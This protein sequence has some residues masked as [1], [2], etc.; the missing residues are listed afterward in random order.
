MRLSALHLDRPVELV[1]V[2]LWE[3]HHALALEGFKFFRVFANAFVEGKLL[4]EVAF[5]IE[6]GRLDVAH[7]VLLRRVEKQE[8]GR[9]DFGVFYLD[10]VP[11]PHLLP[12][13]LFEG[14]LPE[15]PCPSG[16]DLFVPDVPFLNDWFSTLS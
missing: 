3:V 9:D 15:H 13:H 11:Y 4:L 10:E 6:V 1:Q 8:I 12:L 5:P 16:V 14:A 7:R 2:W